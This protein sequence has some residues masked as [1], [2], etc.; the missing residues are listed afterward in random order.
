MNILKLTRIGTNRMGYTVYTDE[1]GNYYIDIS[2]CKG[3]P[4][5]LYT[6]SPQDDMDGEPD[7]RLRQSFKILNPFDE[8]EIRMEQYKSDYMMLSRL[9]DECE[10]FFGRTG[11]EWRDSVDCRYHNERNIWGLNIN[12][13]IVEMK[14]LWEIF[15]DDLKPQW[16]TWENILK[17]EHDAKNI[18]LKF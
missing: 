11:N 10:A 5:E 17:Y 15:P 1:K 3:N 16:C 9:N 2:L 18:N 6:C 12:T 8:K 14:R 7:F 4:T 13:Q